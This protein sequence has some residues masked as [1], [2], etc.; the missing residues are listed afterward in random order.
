MLEVCT[1][2]CWKIRRVEMVDETEI[3][4]TQHTHT[5]KKVSSTT[6]A[7]TTTTRTI[8]YALSDPGC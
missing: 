4:N 8:T 6:N 2:G 1:D 5:Q 3:T 7:T